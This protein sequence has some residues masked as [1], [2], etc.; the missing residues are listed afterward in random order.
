MKRFQST[1]PLRGT[2]PPAPDPRGQADFNPRAP[3]GARPM[4]PNI[5]KNA[6]GISIHVPLAGHDEYFKPRTE[7]D[8]RFQSTCPLRGT[9]LRCGSTYDAR[10]AIS[11][12]V[13]LAGHDAPCPRKRGRRGI[14]I[15]VPL[16]GH[17]PAHNY[18]PLG[19]KYFN[20]RA[21]CGARPG[22][23]LQTVRDQIFQSTCPLRGTTGRVLGEQLRANNFNPRAPCGARPLHRRF[24]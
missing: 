5:A 14:S 20:P 4:A 16:A 10:R 7:A 8:V 6:E 24:F 2:T 3:C 23:Q 22:A 18:R 11:I 13:P 1:C 15:H 19:I 12:H 21:P 17:D 9:T